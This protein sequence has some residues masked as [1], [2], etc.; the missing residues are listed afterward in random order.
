[1][2]CFASTAAQDVTILH[3]KDGTTKRYTNGVKGAT[4]IQFFDYAPAKTYAPDYTS[5]H[6]NNYVADWNVNQVCRID[7]EYVVGLFWE[8]N[9][10]SN[11]K[12]N[13]GVLFGTAPGLTLDNCQEKM[14][15]TDARVQYRSSYG[16][17]SYV[18]N[19]HTH[20]MWIG[21][22]INRAMCMNIDGRN[23][24]SS[25]TIANFIRTPLEIDHTYYYRTFSEGKALVGGEEQTVVFY[26]EERSFRVPRI[27]ADFAYYPYP[28]AT[29]EA[30]TAFA[31]AHLPDTIAV[32]TWKQWEPLW[33]LWR[34]TDEGKNYD[35]SAD[36]TTE[37]FDD[38]TGYRLNRIPD[39]FYTWIANRE[40]VIDPFNV[41][42]IPRAYDKNVKDSV[43]TMILS[44]IENVDEKWGVPGGKYVR[45]EPLITTMNQSVT[46]RSREV[47]PGVRY[48]L[49]L[50][51]APET[52]DESDVARLPMKLNVSTVLGNEITRIVLPAENAKG[53]FTVPAT[54]TT[55]VEVDNFSVKA[56]GLSFLILTHVTNAE[57]RRGQFNRILRIAEMRLTPM[58]DE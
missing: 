25:D 53:D 15:A 45:F 17:L 57:I 49:Q 16:D 47:V 40:I 41:A 44:Y 54:E 4:S 27:M 30:L 10:P 3:M 24:I 35:L 21:S 33:N 32:P 13:H 14:Y 5:K 11:F 55:S 48:K 6:E 43:Y 28:C 37:K 19:E 29:D 20:Y 7:G 38:G 23:F 26:G 39:E 56:V 9:V 12:A 50:N 22:K 51:F 52:E 58:P 8:D 46:Y 1:M 34:A 36:I 31:A 2:G 18:I 42:E